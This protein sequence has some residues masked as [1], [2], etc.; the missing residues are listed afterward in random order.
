MCF[1]LLCA[2]AQEG[3]AAARRVYAGFAAA[4]IALAVL[5]IAIASGEAVV[6]EVERPFSQAQ[7][8]AEYVRANGLESLPMIGHPDFSASAVVGH[9]SPRKRIRYVQGDREGSFVRWDAARMDA[10][11]RGAVGKVVM[12]RT[13]ALAART[14]GKVLM[15]L[16]DRSVV[17]P[18]MPDPPRLLAAF[19]GAVMEGED[20]FLYLYE[21]PVGGARVPGAG[22]GDG[23][24]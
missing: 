10:G 8:A 16:G 2:R 15:V 9:L 1:G 23:R 7:R 12:R 5:H 4:G 19:T 14:G 3:A 18:D 21:T 17:P 20:F 13:E 11:P 22:G 6:I 24:P